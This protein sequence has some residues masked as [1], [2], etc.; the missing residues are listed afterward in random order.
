MDKVPCEGLII[1]E[2]DQAYVDLLLVDGAGI[3]VDLSCANAHT[4]V[5][6]DIK[7]KHIIHAMRSC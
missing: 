6:V 7:R 4:E 1:S 3:E 2:C 5:L